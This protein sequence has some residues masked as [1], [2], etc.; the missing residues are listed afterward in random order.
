M[1]KVNKSGL[2]LPVGARENPIII[3]DGGD[4]DPRTGQF[5]FAK[6]YDSA[7]RKVSRFVQPRMP[8]SC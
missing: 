6:T 4:D 5:K 7:T 3:I 1:R 8:I 2:P